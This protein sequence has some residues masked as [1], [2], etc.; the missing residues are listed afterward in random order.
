MRAWV[1][2][3]PVVAPSCLALGPFL[4]TVGGRARPRARQGPISYH[5]GACVRRSSHPAVGLLG[6]M[7]SQSRPR[8]RRR[9]SWIAGN[10]GVRVRQNPAHQ[11]GPCDCRTPRVVANHQV[12]RLSQDEIGWPGPTG[13]PHCWSG[14]ACSAVA[15]QQRVLG[16]PLKNCVGIEGVQPVFP[17]SVGLALGRDP[18]VHGIDIDS[19][20]STASPRGCHESAAIPCLW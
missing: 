1:G 12:A 6:L 11:A 13:T 8:L 17:A 16:A 9:P 3:G 14:A 18:A 7:S 15:S 5:R 4:N 20:T 19:G 2:H 10:A